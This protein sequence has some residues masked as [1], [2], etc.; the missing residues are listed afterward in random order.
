LINA[1]LDVIEAEQRTMGRT[2]GPTG[3][4][5]WWNTVGTTDRPDAVG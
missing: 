2:I 5:S 3:S 4:P 1:L